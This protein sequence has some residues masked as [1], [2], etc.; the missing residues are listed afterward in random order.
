LVFCA[1]L[2]M[3]MRQ[4]ESRVASAPFTPYTQPLDLRRDLLLLRSMLPCAAN[5]PIYPLF[6]V[7][8]NPWSFSNM[9]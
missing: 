8:V 6:L 3:S 7:I 9:K 1:K 5:S 4:Y 2:S